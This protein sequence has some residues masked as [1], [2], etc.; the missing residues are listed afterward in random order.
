MERPAVDSSL[1]QATSISLRRNHILLLGLIL[2]LAAMLRSF[3]LSRDALWHDE[4]YSLQ[5]ITGH[6]YHYMNL[7]AN[8]VLPAEDVNLFRCDRPVWSIWTS[9]REDTFPPL[10]YM[11][12]RL[13]VN[14]FGEAD[15]SLRI[16]S[17]LFSM[18]AVAVFFDVVR[19]MSGTR[20]GLWAALVMAIAGAQ[21]QMSHEVRAY[22]LVLLLSLLACDAIVRIE[23]FGASSGRAAALAAACLGVMLTHYFAYGVVAALALYAVL[24]LRDRARGYALSALLCAVVLIV[25]TW[26]PFLIQQMRDYAPGRDFAMDAG[27]HYLWDGIDRLAQLPNRMLSNTNETAPLPLIA[28]LLFLFLPAMIALRRREALLWIL[29]LFCL[30][31]SVFAIDLIRHTSQLHYVRYVLTATPALYALLVTAGGR[32]KLRWIIPPLIAFAAATSLPYVVWPYHHDADDW[33][34]IAN[35]INNSTRPDELLVFHGTGKGLPSSRALLLCVSRYLNTP[36]PIMIIDDDRPSAQATA[37]LAQRDHFWLISKHETEADTFPGGRELQTYLYPGICS[38]WDVSTR[39]DQASPA[40]GG[41]I[42]NAV[43]KSIK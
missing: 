12:L 33:R 21:I 2:A 20:Y 13:W 22:S 25:I 18:I 3:Q 41:S 27:P 26:L 32:S 16:L 10:Y 38:L 14:L 23:R 17:V 36:H 6:N 11:L 4:A 42:P 37:L 30:I 39:G 31:G 7:P 40:S 1:S 8:V 5:A 24:R 35:R 28:G 15:L 9:L 43:A 34:A 19:L 29:V